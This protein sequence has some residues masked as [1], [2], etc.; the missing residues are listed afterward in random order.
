MVGFN[1]AAKA[2]APQAVTPLLVYLR[3]D[4]AVF[5][6]GSLTNRGLRS[7]LA[8]NHD[9]RLHLICKS[10]RS[11]CAYPPARIAYAP[12]ALAV[13]ANQT[14]SALLAGGFVECWCLHVGSFGDG[15]S[16]NRSAPSSPMCVPAG[17][18][19]STGGS[20]GLPN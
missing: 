6:S 9:G 20:S 2:P 1:S 11:S 4:F 7:A 12:T 10:P 19:L 13:S 5:D 15:T 3:A 16:A 8:F 14:T 18:V 17:Q